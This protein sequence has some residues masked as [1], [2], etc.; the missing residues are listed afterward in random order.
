MEVNGKLVRVYHLRPGE[1]VAVDGKEE[2]RFFPETKG[3]TTRVEL[4]DPDGEFP[5][6]EGVARCSPRDN[7]NK[8][9]GRTIALGRAIKM[10]NERTP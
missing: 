5:L 7:Y 6:A 4:F 10:L 2:L 8:R 1:M 9:L 3:G